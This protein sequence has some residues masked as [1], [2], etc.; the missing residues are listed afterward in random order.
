MVCRRVQLRSLLG[1]QRVAYRLGSSFL[2]SSIDQYRTWS[3]PRLQCPAPNQQE[4]ACL[5]PRSA[6]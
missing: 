3:T 2:R 6:D 1:P 5:S 4:K